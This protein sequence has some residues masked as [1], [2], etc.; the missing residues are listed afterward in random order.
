MYLY[1]LSKN[2]KRCHISCHSQGPIL[3]LVA[4]LGSLSSIKL[5]TLHSTQKGTASSLALPAF[6]T[7][8]P[9]ACNTSAAL[10]NFG[11]PNRNTYDYRKTGGLFR[12]YTRNNTL[13]RVWLVWWA[14]WGV[15]IVALLPKK[16]SVC[17]SCQN[18]FENGPFHPRL[19]VVA[20][21]FTGCG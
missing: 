8:A 2:T 18:S 9:K 15:C 12:F 13:G 14:L 5:F 4:V 1:Y 16:N 3:P 10:P 21:P 11:G 6:L 7:R 17:S 20:G 19:L